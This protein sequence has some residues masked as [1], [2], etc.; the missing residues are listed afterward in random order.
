[1]TP[2]LK[3][4]D[5]KWFVSYNAGASWIELG[6][7]TGDQGPQGETGA[8][9]PQ[10][11]SGENGA[12][13][14]AFFQDVDTSNSEYVR[15]ILADGTEIKIPTWSAVAAT[16]SLGKL[17]GNTA[18]FNGKVVRHSLDLKVTVYYNT[19]TNLSAYKYKGKTS[20]TEFTGDTFTLKLSGLAANTTYYYFTEVICNGTATFSE[21]SS[22]RTGEPDSYIDWEE[23]DNIQGEI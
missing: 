8:T 15:F 16:L 3:I 5:G 18:T 10:G 19:N 2:Q 13:G 6:Q 20:V 23:G 9:G 4:E 17:T 22:F 11:P 21:V 1:M 12:D 14:D 7:A